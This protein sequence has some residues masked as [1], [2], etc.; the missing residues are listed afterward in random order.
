MA[1]DFFVRC[2]CR[3]RRF[4]GCKSR[5]LQAADGGKGIASA[6][7]ELC[8]A[9]LINNFQFAKPFERGEIFSQRAFL[10]FTDIRKLQEK[11]ETSYTLTTEEVEVL[12]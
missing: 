6:A 3:N 10:I 8:G 2:N 1:N 7:N 11:A 4:T 5:F 12:I 9:A